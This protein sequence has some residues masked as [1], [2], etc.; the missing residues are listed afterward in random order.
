MRD[1]Q[2]RV[3]DKKWTQHRAQPTPQSD[4]RGID[5]KI[6][7]TLAAIQGTLLS[8]I[9]AFGAKNPASKDAQKL[10][11][12]IF[13]EGVGAHINVPYVDQLSSNDVVIESLGKSEYNA[14]V[15]ARG[16]QVFVDELVAL[17]DAFRTELSKTPDATPVSYDEVQAH[18]SRG[19]E[20][21]L[22]I[23]ARIIGQFPT[24]STDDSTARGELLAPILQQNDA[25]GAYLRRRRP[26]PDV[27]PDTGDETDETETD[28]VA[29]HGH[30]IVSS[31]THG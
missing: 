7:R 1:K 9:R 20:Y 12:D 30:T 10:L 27:D 14:T 22:E 4:A 2:T 29:P 26:I 13:P 31:L 5:T 8:P 24:S 17:N 6:D 25:I 23:L 18:R 16:L 3:L 21:L 28:T 19:Q 11:D 15:K